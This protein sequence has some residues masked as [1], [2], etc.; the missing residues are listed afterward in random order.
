[1]SAETQFPMRI[2]SGGRWDRIG[3]A[4]WLVVEPGA[5]RWEFEQNRLRRTARRIATSEP[6]PPPVI[7]ARLPITI[8]RSRLAPPGVNRMLLLEGEEATVVVEAWL[9]WPR[10]R[11]ALAAAGIPTAERVEWFSLGARELRA[12]NAARDAPASS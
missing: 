12:A 10:I 9:R 2:R 7:H 5:V 3:S 11:Q 4:G 6:P 8:L 1:M